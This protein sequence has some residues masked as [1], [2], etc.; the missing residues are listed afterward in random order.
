[1]QPLKEGDL[2]ELENRPASK[3]QEKD[4]NTTS[5]RDEKF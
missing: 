1:M 5:S 4:Y 3:K 2:I